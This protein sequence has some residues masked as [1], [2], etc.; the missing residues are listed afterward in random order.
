VV[1]FCAPAPTM[2]VRDD[3][4]GMAMADLSLIGQRQN[5][6]GQRKAESQRRH[7]GR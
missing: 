4:G 2:R 3:G 5:G 7:N 6:Q 1:D